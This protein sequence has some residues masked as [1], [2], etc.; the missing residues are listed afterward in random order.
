MKKHRK[1][2]GEVQ[3]EEG[4]KVCTIGST[5]EP[6]ESRR[7]SSSGSAAGARRNVMTLKFPA[8]YGEELRRGVRVN[9][10]VEQILEANV[11]LPDVNPTR[12][13]WSPHQRRRQSSPL[14]TLERSV[15]ENSRRKA[16]NEVTKT[17][18]GR[19]RCQAGKEFLRYLSFH[20][21]LSKKA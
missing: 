15:S 13:Y 12:E 10:T 3:R 20:G 21:I 16:L 19:S 2:E 1:P 18:I 5:E 14:S 9:P 8:R 17:R 4:D 7:I 6:G 11:M